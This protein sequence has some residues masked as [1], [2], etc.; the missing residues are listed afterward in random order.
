MADENDIKFAK[1]AEKAYSAATEQKP[2]PQAAPVKAEVVAKALETVPSVAPAPIVAVAAR[3]EPEV[4]VKAEVQ[5]KPKAATTKELVPVVAKVPVSPPA[6]AAPVKKV[7][8]ARKAASPKIKIPSAAKPA[9]KRVVTR[10]IP[11]PAK[12][13]VKSANSQHTPE[14]SIAELK[15][16]IMATA[17]KTTP[18]YTKLLKDVQGKAKAAY[19]KG[20]A[21]AG[22]VVTFSKG[23]VEA[24]VASGKILANGS[25]A[26]GKDYIA[27]SKGAFETLTGDL[28]SLA[29]V[30]SP[31]ELFQLQGKLARRNFDAAVAFSSKSS[32]S[33]VKLANE[34]FAPI[35]NRVSIAVD[36]VSKAA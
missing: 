13:A 28:K 4:P 9:P 19:A 12:L 25:K 15:E 35:S 10:K 20:G 22:E 5:A 33:L 36:K 34:A 3:V 24:V 29:A 14:P 18:D 30:K 16:K 23:N 31:T 2:V 11:K 8:T 32:E 21:V 7:A 27:E 26:L 1:T 17:K 6:K